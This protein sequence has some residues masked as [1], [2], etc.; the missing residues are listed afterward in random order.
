MSSLDRSVEMESRKK[1][2]VK[3]QALILLQVSCRMVF[4]FRWSI[5]RGRRV[6][7]QLMYHRIQAK[8]IGVK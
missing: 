6:A 2:I 1:K 3:G 4:K 7:L 8:D 5:H